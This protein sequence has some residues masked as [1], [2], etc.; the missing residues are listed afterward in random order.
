MPKIE[1]KTQSKK[2]HL[3]LFKWHIIILNYSLP[4]SLLCTHVA[5]LISHSPSH[6]QQTSSRIHQ[7]DL[8]LENI[9]RQ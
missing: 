8:T 1:N 4:L 9:E 3:Q 2:R 5:A 7:I 6:H